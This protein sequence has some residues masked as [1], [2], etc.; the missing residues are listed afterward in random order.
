MTTV[1]PFSNNTIGVYAYE[2]FSYTISN[3]NPSLFTLQTV[4]NSSGF[5]PSPSSLYFTKNGNLSYTFAIT[6][7]STNLT[8]GTTENFILQTVSGSSILTSSNTVTINPGRFLVDPNTSLSNNVYTYYKN[9]ANPPIRLVAPSSI[10]LK[11]PTSIPTLPP[12]LSF[13]K[14][15]SN[16]YDITGIPLV[17]VPNS[18]YQIIGVEEVGS[19]VVTTK[20]NMVI[21]NERLRLNLNGSP[22]ISNMSIGT[23]IVPRTFT[24]VPPEGSGSIRYTFPSLPN[25]ITAT[26][27]LG[28]AVTSPFSPGDL[29][30]TM[31]IQ[32]TPTLAAAEAFRNAG[33]GSNGA[34]YTIQALR[35]IPSPLS[36]SLNLTFAFGET[37]LFDTPTLQPLY[38]GVPLASGQNFFRAATYFTSNVPITDIS[39]TSLPTGLTIVFDASLSRG[40]LVG[41]PSTAGTASYTIRATNSNAI[42]RDFV[43]PITI[44]NDSVS[45]VSPSPPNGS[46]YRFILSRPVDQPK[47]S[48]Y[49]YPITFAAEA[50]SSLPV[51]LSAPGLAG[52]GL[53]LSN[54]TIVGTPSTILPPT[55]VSINASVT[56]SPATA[57]R[58]VQIEILND[59]FY[60]GSVASSNF[61]F[62]Q[63]IPITPFQIPVSTLSGRNVINFTTYGGPTGVVIN[64]AGVVSGTPLDSSLSSV[65]FS[66]V[67]T[68]GYASGL[69]DFSYTLF[70][71]NILLT[72]P[73]SSYTYT[74]GGPISIQVTGTAYSG[75]NV[76]Q[77]TLTSLYG[78]T[79]NATTGL[80]GGNWSDSIPPNPILPETGTLTIGCSANNVTDSLVGTFTTVPTVKRA[81]FAWSGNTFYKYNDV[82]WTADPKVFGGTGFDIV[83]KNTDVNGNFIVATASNLIYRS[84]TIGEFLP[85]ATDQDWCSSLA[86]VPNDSLWWCSGLRLNSD[87]IRRAAVIHSHN[88]ADSWDFLSFIETDSNNYMLS[89][90]SNSNVGNAYL[91][92]GIA[93][94]YGQG[95]L[96]AGGLT[97]DLGSPVMLRSTDE[98]FS[99]RQDITGAF[100]KETAYFNL[101]NPSLWV[102]TGSSGYKSADKLNSI[103]E[104]IFTANTDTIKYST[105]QGQ[106]WSNATGGF[107]MFGY[108]LVYANNTWVA[109]GVDVTSNFP[110]F[111]KIYTPGLKYS[112]NGIDWSNATPFIADISST[113][114]FI[115]PLPIG[116]INYDGSNWNLFR[117]DQSDT[118]VYSSPSISNGYSDWT[119]TSSTLNANTSPVVSY[120]RPQYLR[121]TT[122]SNSPDIQITLSFNLR[123]GEGPLISSPSIRSF[124]LYQ[125]VPV[126]IQLAAAHVSGNVYFFITNS[127]LPAGLTFNPLT[128][129][130]T[131]KPAEI[132]RYS[133]RVFAQDASGITVDAFDFTIQVPRVIRKQDGAGAYT[134]LLKQYTEVLAA[135]SARDQRMLPNQERRLGEFMSPVPPAVITQTFNTDCT[136][137][138]VVVSDGID[139]SGDAVIEL[140]IGAFTTVT[141]FIDA[142]AGEVFDAGSA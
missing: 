71:D 93:L 31:I 138:P 64:P 108:E 23:P 2:G 59:A 122:V 16:I 53:S 24:V 42:L 105:D 5:G 116:S 17:T 92:G 38:V 137:C 36:N 44:S 55:N 103:F 141:A 102:A 130:I 136:D 124:L 7:A 94:K 41:T 51:V 46:S 15:A 27:S 12:G 119:V 110:V 19:K 140:N 107:D 109:T 65:N 79:I 117:T 29:S 67:P 121:T 78:P 139:V 82:S 14:Y 95:V 61:A 72:V 80:I 104:P 47:D 1:L 50:G 20:F 40:N 33:V 142:S 125:Y 111:E 118:K 63:N 131:G 87:T 129:L 11:Q 13:V 74:A 54:G 114:P 75:A 43:T 57:S 62:I 90:D 3:P 25:G 28:N 69:Q 6:D 39:S 134:S 89:R 88:N 76:S 128:N 10:S 127:E 83:I 123:V 4:S 100:E 97:N 21:S 56:G 49:T 34:T 70:P 96:M 133:T 35:T 52:T 18:N 91:R 126:S 106:S 120:T 58:T 32:G 81:S 99:W 30:Y 73:F 48:Y 26:D 101:E 85:Y 9:E 8:A 86:F 112:T 66:V 77:Y 132:G 98:G 60:F 37:V 113:I 45:F 115:A 22:I 84:S 68:T 135:Q